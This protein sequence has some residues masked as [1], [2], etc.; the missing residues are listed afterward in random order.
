VTTMR[1]LGLIGLYALGA[2]AVVALLG[3]VALRG[4]RGRSIAV[5]VGLLLAITVAAVVAGVVAVAKAM[6]LSPHDLQV[7]LITVAASAAVSLAVGVV[8][9]RRLAAS[10]VWAA[11]ARERERRL[12]AGRRELVAWVSHD[13]RT[14]LAGMRAMVEALEDRVVDDPETVAEYHRRIRIEA[15]RMARLVDDLFELSRINAGALRLAMSSVPLAERT[16]LRAPTR[17]PTPVESRNSTFSTSMT[18]RVF[19]LSMAVTTASRSRGA[20]Y[21][22]TS[23]PTSTTVNGPS[24]RVETVNSISLAFLFR[25]ILAVGAPPAL[26]W[27]GGRWVVL[28]IQPRGVPKTRTARIMA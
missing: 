13:L 25:G 14:P 12:E 4:V 15:D 17:T 10:A 2:G 27:R 20:V 16:F 24:F 26:T 21:T 11:Q 23:P 3:V 1:D 19:P 6:F 9:G 22:S 7:V 28:S 5:H 8:F 18:N